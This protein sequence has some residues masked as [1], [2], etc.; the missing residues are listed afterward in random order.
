MKYLCWCLLIICT[1]LQA[2]VNL[3]H[4]FALSL[5]EILK[6]K[7][8]GSTLTEQ[9][10]KTVPSAVTV[11][12][13]EEIKNMGLDSLDEL[14]ILVPG[15]Q[16]YRSSFS[17]LHKPFSA[18]GRRISPSSSEVLI[19]L[20]GQRME[21]SS[22]SGSSEIIPKITLANI[23]RVE[24]IRG[25]GAAVYGSNAM[26]GVVNI[27]TRSEINNFQ[28]SLGSFERH[29]ANLLLTQELNGLTL[30]MFANLDKSDGEQ[31]LLQDSFSASKISSSDPYDIK[32]LNIK[33][34]WQDSQINVFHNQYLGKDFYELDG[35]SN[36]F[37]RRETQV[38]TLSLKQSFNWQPIQSWFW[39]SYSHTAIDIWA[40]LTGQGDLLAISEPA[41]ADPLFFR[42]NFDDF[43]DKRIQ[44]HNDWD[45]D[46]DSQLQFGV[47]VRQ[48]N[49]EKVI[50]QNNFDMTALASGSPTVPFFN[51]LHASSVLYSGST[52]D[53]VGLYGQY[54]RQIQHSNHLTLGLRYDDFSNI[55][56]EVSPRLG[57][58][59]EF[60]EHHSLKLLYG[61]AFRAPTE[62]E[63]DLTNNPVLLG[64]QDLKPETVQSWDLIWLGLW[65]H[66]SFSLGYF[67]NHFEDAIVQASVSD[68]LSQFQN[69]D[70]DPVKGFEFELSR[71]LNDF[72]LIR[73]S[74]THISQNS[75]LSFRETD[76]LA[77]IMV[78]YQQEN[79]NG[80]LIASY[81]GSREMPSDTDNRQTLNSYWQLFA[82]FRY[83][84]NP[85]WSGFIQIK[86]V[87][88]EDF[89][90]PSINTG[91]SEGVV[92]R[93]REIMVGMQLE[94]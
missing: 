72:W 74:Y 45:I 78:N 14:M 5:E 25:P 62:T 2:E 61:S 3:D 53:I 19:L 40:Q 84:F 82:K 7:V 64:N 68:G 66:S 35:L 55:G 41:S 89:R 54:Q 38:N 67:E 85:L 73:A 87:L 34:K 90:T 33:L 81:Q 18:R 63:L 15:F 31:Y 94:F 69:V 27:I 4:Y 50:A 70:M 75:E 20:D 6:I 29:Q 52:R 57:L 17:S 65:P 60:N 56:S 48:I 11:F 83:R 86:N 13:H 21:D 47:E 58:V 8:T 9:S 22:T 59:H 36:G 1:P 39:L 12:H 93:G 77:S 26:M 76:Q 23:E 80:N 43:S 46:E 32:E 71:E 30:D 42:G 79:V 44:L 24:F 49:G 91:L 16:A 51:S 10:I 92:N 28:G 37:N 88:D